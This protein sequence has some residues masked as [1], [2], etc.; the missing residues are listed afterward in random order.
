MIKRNKIEVSKNNL[1]IAILFFILVFSL[2]F[3][4]LNTPYHWDANEQIAVAEWLRD[5][6]FNPLSLRDF[7]FYEGHPLFFFEILALFF[8]LFGESLFVSHLVI[9]IFAF[10]AVY[11]TYFLGKHIY[12]E[13]V[14]FMAAL[15]LFF[16]PIFFAQSGII[17]HSVPLTALTVITIYFMIK[18]NVKAYLISGIICTMTLEPAVLLFLLIPIYIF[19]ENYASSKVK[20]IKKILIYSIPLLVFAAW[21]LSNKLIF[22][23]YINPEFPEWSEIYKIDVPSFSKNLYL[24]INEIFI[25]DYRWILTSILIIYS[26]KLFKKKELKSKKESIFLFLIIISYLIAFSFFK[27]GFLLRY[28]LMVYPFFFILV[29]NSMHKVFKNKL[30]LNVFVLIMLILFISKWTGNRI[31]NC[32]CYLEENLEYLDLIETHYKA[33]KYI[34]INFPKSTVLTNWPQHMELDVPE[35]GYVNKEIKF[36]A[37]SDPDLNEKIS[38]VDLVYYSP[39]SDDSS[40]WELENIMSDLNL[41]LL[42]RFEKNGK[43]TEVYRIDH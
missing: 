17:V 40:R 30:I 12:D 27:G 20:L 10:I 42:K 6:N 14:G 8:D 19:Y 31:L 39:Q 26:I 2:K 38:E 37:P 11:F 4:I 16:C 25:Y 15:L 32:G 18:K 41:T 21:M 34:E 7:W 1:F 22:G 23:W 29:S 33:V 35:Y 13:K 28:A 24:R 5:N 43:Y 3:S 9:V 36:V